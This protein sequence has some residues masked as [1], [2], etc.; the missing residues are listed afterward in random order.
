MQGEHKQ[1]DPKIIDD[2]SNHYWDTGEIFIFTVYIG[3]GKSIAPLNYKSVQTREKMVKNAKY[4][5]I[6]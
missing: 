2:I 4:Y 3:Q 6:L 1:L 5:G